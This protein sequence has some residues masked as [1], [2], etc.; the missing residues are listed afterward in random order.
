MSWDYEKYEIVIGLEVHAQLLTK[1]KLFCSDSTTFGAEANM[2][3]SPISL[4]HP[5]T[6]PVLN[7]KAIEYAVKMGLACQSRIQR[8]NHF[9][10]KNYF[11]PDLPKGYQISQHT[12]PICSGGFVRIRTGIA[13][14]SV[15]LNR[16]HLEEDAGKSL[17]DLD[18]QNSCIDF[19]RAGMPLIEI[20]TEPCLQTAE[21]AH[22]YL[23]EL[24][25]ILRYL[26][27]CDGN[28]EEGSLRCDVN[29]SIRLKGQ[30]ELGTKAEIKNL[31]SLRHVKQAIEFESARMIELAENDGKILQETRS[32]DPTT[33]GTFAL[34]SKE[35][36]DDYRYFADPDLPPFIITDSML[37]EI[38]ASLPE[39]PE[40]LVARYTSQLK[41]PEY[42]ARVISEDKE[43]AD[44]FDQVIKETSNYK[45]VANWLLGPVKSYLNDKGKDMAEFRV[46]PLSMAKLIHLVEEGKINFSIASSRIF[47]EMIRKAD[48]D[49]LAI[50]TALNLLQNSDTDEIIAW[51][52]EVLGSMPDK[53]A[54]YKKGK[55]GLIGLFV[56]EVKRISKGKADPALTNQLLIQKLDKRG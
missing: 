46:S 51:V 15:E 33:G 30:T 50:A 29:I 34:R 4:G 53:V 41:L 23:S 38:H 17:H 35:E 24:R 39:L 47:P 26:K 5:G 13:G 14:K 44:Y 10:R 3:V 7:R 16:I 32:F 52:E 8:N 12:A 49:P 54:E 1:S 18:E 42:D 21:E 55:K 48:S 25:K 43:M 45:A 22:A 27:I 56:G 36:E 28:M 6:L 37:E 11:Y 19:N 31:N 40:Q 20:V 9:A 2:Q